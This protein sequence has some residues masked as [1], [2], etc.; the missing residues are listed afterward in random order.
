MNQKTIT[1]D[2]IPIPTGPHRIGIAKRGRLR[3]LGSW[4]F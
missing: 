4:S 3:D 2:T 1:L